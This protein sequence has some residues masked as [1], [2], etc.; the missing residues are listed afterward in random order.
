LWKLLH[1]QSFTFTGILTF[2]LLGILAGLSS[3]FACAVAI[4]MLNL[5]APVK[6]GRS[7]VYSIAMAVWATQY[8]LINAMNT[9]FLPMLRTTP[10]LNLTY[11]LMG[12][13]IG[14]NVFFNSS[15]IYEPHLVTIGNN[16]RIGEN[17]VIV[18][19]TTEG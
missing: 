6:E 18:P 19:H 17:A 15:Y 9:L 8:F 14:K 13:R 5:I 1:P 4:R 7:S 3:L 16:S 11:R 10:L 2:C 12:A